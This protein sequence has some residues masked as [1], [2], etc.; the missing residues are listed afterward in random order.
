MK[1]V[2]LEVVIEV[3]D[4]FTM[5]EPTWALEDAVG[6]GKVISC[7]CLGENSS[8]ESGEDVRGVCPRTECIW[9]DS[10][11]CDM[12]DDLDMPENVRECDNYS[13]N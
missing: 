12:W 10:G 8:A 4:D 9:N 1:Q 11:H 5:D 2:K 7:N 3:E 13:M 6:N